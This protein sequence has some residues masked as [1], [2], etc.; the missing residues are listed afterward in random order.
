MRSSLTNPASLNTKNRL[1]FLFKD[2]AV[3]GVSAAIS[4]AFALFTFPLLARHFTVEEYGV[5]DYFLVL[6]GLLAIFFIFGQDSAVARFF[7]EYE[8]TSKRKQI[9]SQSLAFQLL[10]MLFFLPF[11]WMGADWLTGFMV[12]SSAR[13]FI[14]KIILLQLP[15]LLLINFSQNL[16]KW[17]F[18]RNR[19][20]AI[21]LGYTV[22]YT[23]LLFLAVMVFDIGIKGVLIINLSTSI[24]FGLLGLF[25]VRKWL[26]WPRNFRLVYEMLPFAIPYGIIC[27]AGAFS[28][29]LERLL[30]NN[31][32]GTESLGLYAAGTK[33]AMLMS[34]IVSAF[35]TSWGPFSL[36]LHKEKD[37]GY[38]YNWVLKLFTVTICLT[39]LMISLLAQPIIILLASERYLGSLVVVFPLAMGLAIQATSWIT[40]IGIGFSKRSHLSLYAYLL[41]IFVTLVGIFLLTPTLGLLGVGFGVLLGHIVKALVAS[42]LA[43]RAYPLPWSYTSTMLLIVLTMV[44]GLLSLWIGN[45]FGM[46]FGNL[47]I[48]VTIILVVLF[49][50]VILFSSSDR[51]KLKMLLSRLTRSAQA[52]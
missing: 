48:S 29:A 27:I 25:F 38:T 3:Y 19:F 5:L 46:F 10:G 12:A 26:I 15:F 47:V 41:A 42:F 37:A 52:H 9:I 16:L 30:I 36:S 40:E 20:L 50:W 1:S 14:F 32:L 11:L 45:F 34:L 28:P 31:L 44:G 24:V 18:T 17:T 51:N 43:Q 7:Y 35:Q 23:S 22:M 33:I 6:G 39:V 13:V 8:E 49:A 2:S 21:S 4:K